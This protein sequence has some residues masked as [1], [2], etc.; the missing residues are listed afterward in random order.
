MKAFDLVLEFIKEYANDAFI[1]RTN[2]RHIYL[3]REAMFKQMRGAKDWPPDSMHWSY[4][5]E[6]TLYLT[7]GNEMTVLKSRF[8]D[9]TD[10]QMPLSDPDC[11]DWVLNMLAQL[12]PEFEVPPRSNR[13]KARK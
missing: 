6:L 2:Q 7:L 5:S 4:A 8:F 3:I 9:P 12:P 11:L 10:K 1:V 13:E